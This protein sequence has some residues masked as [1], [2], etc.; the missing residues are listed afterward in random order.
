[1]LLT[2]FIQ[3]QGCFFVLQ[4][5]RKQFIINTL[6]IL[7]I[8]LS[9]ID[10]MLKITIRI[11]FNIDIKAAPVPKKGLPSIKGTWVSSSIFMIT[12]STGKINLPTLTS[13][14]S[15]TPYGCAIDL[16]AICNVIAVGVSSPKLNLCTTDRGI[17]F[18]LAPESHKAFLNSYFP[19]E[20]GMVKLP[21][22][23]IFSGSFC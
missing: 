10:I 23:F 9:F 8:H 3:A 11:Q 15:R 7:E 12:K 1:M 16:S 17:K 19:I 22:S 18:I 6:K 2:I 13:T 14:S 20:Q 21:G 4:T 5:G